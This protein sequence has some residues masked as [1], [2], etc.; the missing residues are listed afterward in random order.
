MLDGPD[1]VTKTAY[2][3]IERLDALGAKLENCGLSPAFGAV[4]KQTR[5]DR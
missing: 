3:F 5:V 2:K 4:M 1:E